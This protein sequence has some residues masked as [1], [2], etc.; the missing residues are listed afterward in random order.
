MRGIATELAGAEVDDTLLHASLPASFTKLPWAEGTGTWSESTGWSAAGYSAGFTAGTRSGIYLNTERLTGGNGFMILGRSGAFSPSIDRQTSVWLFAGVS[1]GVPNGYQLDLIQV[2]GETDLFT[3]ILR[4]WV[5]GVETAFETATKVSVAATGAFAL[6]KRD[7]KLSAWAS[8]ET[9]SAFKAVTSRYADTA[10]SS[11]YSAIGGNGSTPKFKN[12][13]TGILRGARKRR[14]PSLALD[15][16][17]ETPDGLHRLSAESPHARFRP[18]NIEFETQRGEG[19]ATASVTVSREIFKEWPDLNLLDTWRFISQ[20]DE[21]VYEGRLRSMPATNTPEEQ[22]T[23]NLIGWMGYLRGKKINPLIIDTRLSSWGDP[24]VDR[25]VYITGLNFRLDAN[26]SAGWQGTGE[27]PPGILIDFNGI[28]STSGKTD[29]GESWFYGGGEDIGAVLY[30]FVNW[31]GA[32]SEVWETLVTA[33]EDDNGIGG[34]STYQNGTD[35]KAATNTNP[36]E[37]FKVEKAGKKYA[38]FKSR[39]A[40]GGGGQALPDVQEW[41]YPKVIGTHE[42]TLRGTFP[43]VGFYLTDIMQYILATYYPKVEWAGEENKFVVQ[44]ASWHDSAQFGYDILKELNNLALWELN[45][46]EGPALSYERADLAKTDWQFKTT[47]EGI[48]VGFEGDA[49]ENVANGCSV[50]YTDPSGVPRTLLPSD[51]AELRDE[52]PD[53]P[54]NKHEE[55]GWTD[56]DVPYP[57]NLAEALQ[58]GRAYLEEFNR[59][60]RP[61]QF[62]ISGGFIKDGAGRWQPGFKPRNGQSVS[63]ADK[64][65][66]EPRLITATKWIDGG[67]S[68]VITTDAPPQEIDAMV[69]RQQIAREARGL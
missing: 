3:F 31:V 40:G 62:T 47:D 34:E 27:R 45:M 18:Y 66:E 54:Y 15:V 2:S 61:A 22:I 67:K 11:G 32:P 63:V 9:G 1:E 55:D 42:L 13:A 19:F 16:E 36:Y 65:D 53:N 46:W 29:S 25:R 5:A 41:E 59:P 30:K 26:V 56:C 69:A 58:Y 20:S 60:K 57:V 64:I 23:L 14:K 10:F 21:I 44:Q 6:V 43:E 28:T 12:F 49:I 7:G 50:H 48:T 33:Y 4:K 24:S 52:S 38:A 68:L 51:Y 17:I 39:R 35:Y 37:T 8:K